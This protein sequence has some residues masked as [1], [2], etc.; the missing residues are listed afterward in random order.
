MKSKKSSFY[1]SDEYLLS[2]IVYK[3]YTN[4]KEG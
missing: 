3:N 1:N 4:I 2:M